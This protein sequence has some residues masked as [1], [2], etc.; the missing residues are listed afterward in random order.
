MSFPHF[1][2]TDVDTE[3]LGSD[4]VRGGCD[5]CMHCR[6]LKMRIAKRIDGTTKDGCGPAEPPTASSGRTRRKLPEE[7]PRSLS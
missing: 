1:S 2:I 7:R 4:Q 3:T 6:L 5:V